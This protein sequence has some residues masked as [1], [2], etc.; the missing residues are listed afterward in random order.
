[1]GGG[2]EQLEGGWGGGLSG[3]GM[4]AHCKRCDTVI[5]SKCAAK[6]NLP[7]DCTIEHN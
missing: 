2:R 1:M 3:H 5:D 4:H 7:Q 6:G